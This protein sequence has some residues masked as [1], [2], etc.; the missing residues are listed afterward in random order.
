[1]SIRFLVN[2]AA[3]G[4]Q[5][6]RALS[7]LGE[8]AAKAGAELVVSQN[9]EDLAAQARRA[10]EDGVERLVAAGGDGTF[11]HV[12]QGLID[13]ECAMGLVPL[14]RG[15]DL[16]GTLGI[17][18]E[19]PRAVEVAIGGPVRRIDVGQV[20]RHSFLGYCG[21]GF[22]SEVASYVQQGRGPFSGQAAYVYGVLRT[23]AAFKP[24]VIR[25]EHDGGVYESG[26]MFAV[27]CNHSRFGGGMFIAPEAR[28]DDGMLDLVV[29][30]AVSKLKLL[31]IFPKVYKGEHV[32]HP[33]VTIVRTRSARLYVD[34][35][36]TMASDGEPIMEVGEQGVEVSV[37]PG[38]LGVVVPD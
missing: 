23:L 33:A 8:A 3:G 18:S 28:I 12:A 25:V 5:G 21:V 29:V 20:D 34:R 31:R 22:D 16:A 35:T 30:E 15:N 26:A 19:L 32:G 10:A 1:M 13:S 7:P 36:M 24:P 2:P 4:G 11:H 38:A 9:V 6:E 27:V 14:G 37:R 17:P